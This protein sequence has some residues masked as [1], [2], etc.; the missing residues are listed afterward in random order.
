MIASFI[1]ILTKYALIALLYPLRLFPMRKNRIL[2]LSDLNGKYADNPKY[3][4]R[5]LLNNR[6]G[7]Y[8][9]IFALKDPAEKTPEGVKNVK[10]GSFRYYFYA[11]TAGT[12]VTNSGGISYLPFR[13]KQIVINTWHGGGAYKKF[14]LDFFGRT[15]TSLKNARLN[16]K[17]TTLMLASC[18]ASDAIYESAMLIPAEKM[19]HSGSPRNDIFFEGEAVREKV[20]EKLGLGEKKLCLYAPT[21]RRSSK[22]VFSGAE[23]ALYAVDAEKTLQAL[24]NRFGGEWV[25]GFRYHPKITERRKVFDEAV[26]DFSDYGDMQELLLAADVLINDYSSSMWDFALTG[27]PCFLFCEDIEDYRN[28]E[29]FYTPIEA[30]PFPLAEDMEGLIGAIGGFE[31]D[32]YRKAVR[33]HYA[34]LGSFETGHAS[35]TVCREIEKRLG[36]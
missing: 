28:K 30:W 21:F 11:L 27:K 18:L 4:A 14:N 33:A 3:L 24:K 26:V 19:L 8:E 6:P 36:I 7:K 2:M 32:G 9:L 1:H 25:F 29:D 17:K 13:K 22:S 34:A 5:W 10:T 16:E 20:R 23:S 35:E 12:F 31:E 15:E